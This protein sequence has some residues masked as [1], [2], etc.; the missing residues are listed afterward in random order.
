MDDHHY[1]L[2]WFGNIASFG[3]IVTTMAG[4]LPPIGALVA[5]IWY[6]IQISESASFQRWLHTRRERKIAK[7][8][9]KL[10]ELEAMKLLEP[11]RPAD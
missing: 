1:L 4:L 3:A 8:R 11:E 9:A 7:L 5:I 2:S 6:L 10:L